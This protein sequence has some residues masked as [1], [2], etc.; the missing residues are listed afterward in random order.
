MKDPVRCLKYPGTLISNV[1]PSPSAIWVGIIDRLCTLYE[2]LCKMAVV[3][4]QIV[5]LGG[6]IFRPLHHIPVTAVNTWA[7]NSR[8][9]V[10]KRPLDSP[11]GPWMMS[12]HV[13]TLSGSLILD[14]LVSSGYL[15]SSKVTTYIAVRFFC[16]RTG[17]G[18]IG[19]LRFSLLPCFI[20]KS[21]TRRIRDF[22]FL[23]GRFPTGHVCD[24]PYEGAR[25]YGAP[26]GL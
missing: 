6:E 25:A 12:V 16:F 14:E 24:G 4:T 20:K 18:V 8:K 1:C 5:V 17:S 23:G 11:L 3:R 7:S 21:C 19:H 10:S 9:L 2:Q 22:F 26:G 13:S 15:T